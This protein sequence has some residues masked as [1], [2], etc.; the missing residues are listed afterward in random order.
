MEAKKILKLF[1][2]E[3]TLPITPPKTWIILDILEGD[4]S[5]L[6]TIGHES[7]SC[8]KGDN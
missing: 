8:W 4:R 3:E 2:S 5:S 1:K 6:E 7:L